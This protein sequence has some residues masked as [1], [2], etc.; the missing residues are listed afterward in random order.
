MKIVLF[1]TNK[2]ITIYIAV[3]LLFPI[4]LYLNNETNKYEIDLY[5]SRDIYE[6]KLNKLKDNLMSHF[7]KKQNTYH[8]YQILSK[9]YCSYTIL[10][11]RSPGTT[12]GL[13][14]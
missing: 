13:I 8:I 14:I 2:T 5:V 11:C 3:L 4:Y 6:S 1:L 10:P 12:S 7:Y 9:L